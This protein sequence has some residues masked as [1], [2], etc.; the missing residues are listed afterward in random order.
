[1]SE[2]HETVGVVFGA[3]P[4]G[5]PRTSL[6]HTLRRTNGEWDRVLCNRVQMDSVGLLDAERG[7]NDEPTCPVCKRRDPRFSAGSRTEGSDA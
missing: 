5:K 1:M 6:T 2:T 7:K 4:G 3:Y